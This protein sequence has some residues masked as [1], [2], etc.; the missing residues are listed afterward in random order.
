MPGLIQKGGS[1]E[2]PEPP[3]ATGLGRAVRLA[4]FYE[5]IHNMNTHDYAG[6]SGVQKFCIERV[7]SKTWLSQSHT[8]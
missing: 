3:L 1:I 6:S 8:R 7:V 4:S 2:P 5:C